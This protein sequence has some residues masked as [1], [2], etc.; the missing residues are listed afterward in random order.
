MKQIL[1]FFVFCFSI[2]VLNAQY[3]ELP[4]WSDDLP[5]ALKK[6]EIYAIGIS[7]PRMEDDNFAE[8]VAI[9]RA[10][11]L[12]VIQ[13]EVKI[14]YASDYFEKKSE[15]YRW[16]V[17][18]EDVQE[19]GK[20]KASAHVDSTN[21]EIVKT[22]INKNGETIV[23]LKFMPGVSQDTNFFVTAE[24]YRQ[25]FEVSNTRAHESIRSIKLTTDWI[26]SKNTDTLTTF[27]HMTNFNGSISTEIKHDTTSIVPPGYY[28]RYAG[29][30]KE[31]FDIVDYNTSVSMLKGLWIAYIDSFMQSIMKLSKNYSS[32]METVGDDYKVNRNDGI[33]ET[34]TESLAR[35]VCINTLT[36]TYGGMD[37]HKNFLYPRIFLESKRLYYSGNGPEEIIDTTEIETPKK[38]C[39]L[40]RL[41]T[42]KKKKKQDEK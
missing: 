5:Y 36:F 16:F 13:N 34:S 41:F 12:A 26:V 27:F 8:E 29:T 22:E 25:D 19:L 14:Y 15:E 7:D 32:K 18:K 9:R 10:L 28:Y 33:S 42:C 21:Y 37:V 20:I 23:L 3:Y 11:T 1:V 17:M 2:S 24:Y 38:K 6:G 39:W 31:G 4:K 40:G 35:S 30:L